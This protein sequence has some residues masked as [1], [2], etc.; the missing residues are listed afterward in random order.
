MMSLRIK[1]QYKDTV[2]A[3][4]DSGVALYKRSCLQLIDLALLAHSSKDPSILKFFEELPTV[5][6]LKK[7]KMQE[8]EI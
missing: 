3:F 2:I 1:P 6:E 5:S 8:L 7:M 4:Q